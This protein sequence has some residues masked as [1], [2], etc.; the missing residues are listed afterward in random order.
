M[1]VVLLM[2]VV[3][4]VGLITSCNPYK[5]NRDV[6]FY[7]TQEQKD[8]IN[9]VHAGDTA[10]WESS[11]GY[12]DSAIIQ[13]VVYQEFITDYKN[14]GNT[15]QQR[16]YYEHKFL[17][18]HKSFVPQGISVIANSSYKLLGTSLLWDIDEFTTSYA[19]GMFASRVIGG[20]LY[21]NVYWAHGLFDTKDTVFWSN[22]GYLL[23]KS[24]SNG[25]IVTKIK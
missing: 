2:N 9:T 15:Y 4:F 1:R 25:E 14:G 24:N 12:K 17:G 11:L 22:K 13:P 23:C 16:G 18:V 7:L 3:C 8:F 10:V 5:D 6:H 21:K 20:V 19:D